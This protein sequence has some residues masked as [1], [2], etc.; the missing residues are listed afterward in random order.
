MKAY[1]LNFSQIIIVQVGI[2]ILLN[3]ML[4]TTAWGRATVNVKVKG[5]TVD[6]VDVDIDT[7][8]L[9]FGD[10]EGLYGAF[11]VTKKNSNG[12]TMT[13]E[14]LQ[15]EIRQET[16][17]DK[18]HF[19]WLQIITHDTSP[20]NDVNGN[21][22]SAPY[23]DLPKNGY[24]LPSNEDGRWADDKPWY[25]DEYEKPDDDND[26]RDWDFGNLLEERVDGTELNFQDYPGGDPAGNELDFLTFLVG[27]FG[28][29]T[30]DFLSGFKWSTR[31]RDDKTTNVTR[32]ESLG[33]DAELPINYQQQVLD[34]F[35]FT[36][37]PVL[38]EYRGY[39]TDNL[40]GL[41][42][43]AFC[44]GLGG[45]FDSVLCGG[46]GGPPSGYFPND[47]GSFGS[48]PLGFSLPFFGNTYNSFYLN[49]N[50]NISFGNPI[51][52]YTPTSVGAQSSAPIIAPYWADVDT[53]GTGTVAVRTDIPNQVIVTWDKVG[54]YNQNTDK[55]A[56]F[57]LV[58][59]GP[60][61][62]TPANEGNVGFFY[63]DVQWE[64]GDASGGTGGFGGTP[65][66]IGFGDGLSSVNPSELS[67]NGSQQPGISQLVSNRYFWFNLPASG[68]S[69]DNGG[70]CNGGGG[71]GGGGCARTLALRTVNQSLPIFDIDKD[72]TSEK[73]KSVPESTP[74]LGLLALGAWSIVK[75]LKIKKDK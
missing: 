4:S 54:Y 13:I 69:G 25:F 45:V 38:H 51:G 15:N 18:F 39:Y 44:G 33:E 11:K 63:K 21:L 10:S 16:G 31:I 52:A 42:N 7:I 62:P 67:L 30:Y 43:G 35:G 19:N 23:I 22:L 55:L 8:S 6:L 9:D 65:A 49:N 58:L 14:Q 37:V 75:A 48:Y 28:N 32:L 72:Y 57:Q 27:D 17:F 60:D 71:S 73:S 41:F 40:G 3:T 46:I 56:S 12:T 53:R 74:A 61:Y 47:D 70:G 5:E 64:T 59:R 68:D 29:Q 1:K 2:A 20:P 34:E 26:V 50:G 66:A 24:E 36:R